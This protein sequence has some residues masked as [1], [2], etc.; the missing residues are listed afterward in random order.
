MKSYFVV[1]DVA[2][3]DFALSFSSKIRGKVL[4][5]MPLICDESHKTLSTVESICRAMLLRQADKT[6][7]LL[8]IGGG[9]CSDICGLAA[10]IYKRG[11]RFETV[12]TTLLAMADAAV[13]GKNGVNLDGVK[14]A[15]GS[16]NF[17][18]K[19]H[20]RPEVLNTLS[21]KQL[22]SG[23]AEI[24]KTFLLFDP[25]LYANSLSSL[26]SLYLLQGQDGQGPAAEPLKSRED[27]LKELAEMAKKAAGYKMKVVKRD[28]FDKG[29]RHLLN[30]GH[31]FGHAIEYKYAQSAAAERISHG[32][33][34]AVGIVMA[35]ELSEGEGWSERGLAERIKRDFESC[36]LPTDCLWTREELREAIL[37]DKKSENGKIDFVYVRRPGKA[38]RKKIKI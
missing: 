17:P 35:Q 32:E 23:G 16:Y 29:L 4:G 5:E 38:A 15:I 14:N 13:G 34:V 8:S 12:P 11:I 10:S 26:R 30:Y 24:L 6:C 27:V 31:S 18:E 19:T 3:K 2:V 25:K 7:T 21:Y 33:A 9:V 22:L 36:G 20:Y 1:Y 28:K 37:N